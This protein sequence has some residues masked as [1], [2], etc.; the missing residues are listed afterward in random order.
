VVTDSPVFANSGNGKSILAC[1][2]SSPGVILITE[3]ELIGGLPFTEGLWQPSLLFADPQAGHGLVIK[4]HEHKGDF[5][6]ME[7]FAGKYVL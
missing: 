1:C 7:K 4:T 3:G 6:E 2:S 5:E